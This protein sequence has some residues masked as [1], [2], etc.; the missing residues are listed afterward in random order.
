[1]LPEPDSY[2]TIDRYV[3]MI[4]NKKDAPFNE[5]TMKT[6]EHIVYSIANAENNISKID[7]KTVEGQEILKYEGY[8][9]TKTRHF[10]NNICERPGTKYIEIGTWNGS[11][12]ISTVYKNNIEEALFIDNWCQFGGT[13]DIFKSAINKFGQGSKCYLLES[14]CWKVDLSTIG[15][16][17]VY[18]YDGDHAELDHFKALEYYLQVLDDEFI[19]IVDDFNFYNVRD[20]TMRAINKLNLNIKFR[21]EIFLSPDQL[22]G[23]PNHYGKKTWWNGIAIYLLEKPKI[24]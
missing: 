16:F 1:M 9:G 17:N 13:S 5:K 4:Q 15:K 23:M 24:V 18:L 2:L 3:N 8:T 21:H 6:I 14:D 12:S 7:D 19:F 11:S 22:Q 10:Y 20:G